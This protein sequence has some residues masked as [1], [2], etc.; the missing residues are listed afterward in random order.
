[1]LTVGISRNDDDYVPE[2]CT[3]L[4]TTFVDIGVDST[5]K[6]N[7]RWLSALSACYLRSGAWSSGRRGPLFG[8]LVGAGYGAGEGV[9]KGCINAP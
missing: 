8:V 5:P 3:E 2:L 7:P 1:M 9:I 6:R 4:S